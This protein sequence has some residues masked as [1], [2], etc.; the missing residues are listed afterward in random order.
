M[1]H[2]CKAVQ[3][4]VP[5]TTVMELTAQHLSN[6]VEPKAHVHAS[7]HLTTVPGT[8][9]HAQTASTNMTTAVVLQRQK[10]AAQSG[11]TFYSSAY[12]AEGF[13]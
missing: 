9:L 13:H 11:L 2:A 6:A 4:S 12:Q 10:K 3:V 1:G 5:V 8:H 7:V